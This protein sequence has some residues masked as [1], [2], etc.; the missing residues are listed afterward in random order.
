MQINDLI[1]SFDWLS[2]RKN[3]AY[4]VFTNTSSND[5]L[6]WPNNVSDKSSGQINAFV[7]WRSVSESADGVETE[8]FLAKPAS[9]QTKFEIPPEATA[10]VT[11]RRL[12]Q[13]L[14]APGETVR[15]SYGDSSGEVRA[16]SKGCVTVPKLKLTS[17]PVR[18]SI[19][20]AK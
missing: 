11:L 1:N 12:Q 15:W 10:D 19:R 3:E 13:L 4:P 7:R 17:E 8:L 20:K 14:I 6:P 16:D 2:V 9:L 5:P 18:L